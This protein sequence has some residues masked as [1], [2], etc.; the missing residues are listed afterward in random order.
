[1]DALEMWVLGMTPSTFG[2]RDLQ[3]CPEAVLEYYVMIASVFADRRR[4]AGDGR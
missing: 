4:G 2:W 3:D 1:M